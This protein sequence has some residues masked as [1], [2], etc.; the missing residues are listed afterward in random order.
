VPLDNFDYSIS[1][2]KD[3]IIN[4]LLIKDKIMDVEQIHSVIKS[5]L[6]CDLGIDSILELLEELEKEHIVIKS[7]YGY[8]IEQSKYVELVNKRKEVIEYQ[9]KTLSKWISQLIVP[10]YRIINHDE[11]IE[12]KNGLVVFLSKLLINH[13]LEVIRLVENPKENKD[14]MHSIFADEIIKQ[15]PFSSDHLYEIA[16]IEYLNF[17][18]EEDADFKRY[19]DTIIKISFRYLSTIIDP[20]VLENLKTELN[21]KVIYLDTSIIYRLFDL[22]GSFRARVTKEVV[23][24][25]KEFNFRL[26][27]SYRTYQELKS[28]IEFDSKVLLSHPIPTSLAVLGYRYRTEE[29]FVSTFWRRKQENPEL[30]PDDYIAVYK[31]IDL[32]LQSEGIYVEK[33]KPNF[34]EDFDETW[35]GIL[36]KINVRDDHEKKY[37]AA[38]HDA[39]LIS[40]VLSERKNKIISN[41][42]DCPS[43]ILTSDQFIIKFQRTERIF[44]HNEPIALLPSQLIQLLRFAR[45]TDGKYVQMFIE[46]F[47]RAYVPTSLPE[48]SNAEIQKILS[49]ISFYKGYTPLIAEKVLSDQLF[50]NR[51]RQASSDGEKEELIHETL[52]EKAKEL[53]KLASQKESELKKLMDQN[54]ELIAHNASVISENKSFKK[55][56]EESNS[57]IIKSKS[58]IEFLTKEIE[59]LRTKERE[60]EENEKKKKQKKR[61]IINV[62]LQ[63]VYMFAVLFASFLIKEFTSVERWIKI[64]VTLILIGGIFPLTYWLYR[65]QKSIA[66]VGKIAGTILSILSS[67]Y[68]IYN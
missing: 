66:I 31:N 65:T 55:Q 27:V 29:N 48:L 62:L 54:K 35:K 26:V 13:G 23:N 51:Y 30:K 15:L 10:K 68:T 57:E 47:S 59:A 6:G 1:T 67:L 43:W 49:R 20:E 17:L 34:S 3:L 12:L 39:F 19:L 24:L 42:I 7:K 32:L 60:R 16:S 14:E 4:A 28:R 36:S 25:C 41:F 45:P 2:K 38:D 11:L 50:R 58:K 9:E 46:L 56:L 18:Y 64:L 44:N 22:Q 21:G 5:Q 52:I 53:E 61:A 37:H 33:E 40:L 63:I 8:I